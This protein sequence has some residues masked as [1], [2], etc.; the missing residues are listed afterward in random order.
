[1]YNYLNPLPDRNTSVLFDNVME[2]VELVPAEQMLHFPC[3]QK[4]SKLSILVFQKCQVCSNYK[5][6]FHL[7]K[8]DIWG[9]GCN[10]DLSTVLLKQLTF[11]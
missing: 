6:V 3:I 11:N 4:F 2:N 7:S 1:M 9:N 10:I 5:K 8:Y